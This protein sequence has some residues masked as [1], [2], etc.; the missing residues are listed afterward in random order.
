MLNAASTQPAPKPSGT[1]NSIRNRNSF[2]KEMPMSAID[3]SKILNSVT[4]PVPSLCSNLLANRLD[5]TVP[6]DTV[7]E[8]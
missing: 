2:V 6:K 3:V 1:A 5:I 4:F 7:N 8:M